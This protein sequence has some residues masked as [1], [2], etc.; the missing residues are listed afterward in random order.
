MTLL[1]Q[2]TPVGCAVPCV[3]RLSQATHVGSGLTLR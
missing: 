2:A 1:S 3:T